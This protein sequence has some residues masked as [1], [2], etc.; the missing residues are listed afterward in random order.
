MTNLFKA[1]F[2][3]C[4]GSTSKLI[5]DGNGQEITVVGRLCQPGHVILSVRPE[6]VEL[7]DICA[8][9]SENTWLAHVEFEAYFGDHRQYLLHNG[10]VA[11]RVKTGPKRIFRRGQ[12]V[13]VHFPP[14][15]IVI[16]GQP[17]GAYCERQSDP[18]SD[19]TV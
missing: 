17:Y 2:K 9:P 13:G 6:S 1:T 10:N 5:V 8:L 14:N 18:T 16:V 19:Q 15:N 11:I 12:T 3:E 4:Y 7:G